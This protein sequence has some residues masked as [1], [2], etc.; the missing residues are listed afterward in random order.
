VACYTGGESVT[1]KDA[2]AAAW[3]NGELDVMIISLRSGAGLDGLQKAGSVVVFGEIDWSPAVHEQ[4]IGRLW[5]DGMTRPVIAYY[6][7]SASG[8]DP[9][10]ADTLG[11]KRGQSDGIRNRTEPIT[12]QA[13]PLHIRRLA[14]KVLLSFK[15]KAGNDEKDGH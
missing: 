10:I 12:E 13:D 2:S 15:A 9:V 3:K 6:L 14:E 4:C 7:L 8:S 5:R 1:E 11:V